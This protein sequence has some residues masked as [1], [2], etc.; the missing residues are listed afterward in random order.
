MV[1]GIQE[2][3]LDEQMISPPLKAENQWMFQN[4]MFVWRGMK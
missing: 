3:E 4:K 1:H 2:D